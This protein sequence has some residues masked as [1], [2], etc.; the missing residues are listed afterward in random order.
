MS[1]VVF[2]NGNTMADALGGI[3]RSYR[4]GFEKLGYEF[5]DINLT[6]KDRATKQLDALLRTDVALAFSFMGIGS[7]V[8]VGRPGG[9]TSVIWET[10]G[11][12]Y[13][14]L[15]GDSPSYFFDRHVLPNPGYVALYG[16]P[17]HFELRK[18]FPHINGLIDTYS[19]TAIDVLGKDE[20]DF[21]KK[22][23]GTIVL[24]KNSNDP[25][26]LKT[27]WASLPPKIGS[28]ILEVASELEARI[29][30][31]ATTQIDDL[32]TAYFKD[33]DIDIAALT[34]LRLF[35]V[36]QLDDYLRRLKST[37]VVES[38]LDLPVVLN[39]Y[40]WDHV[41]FSGRR[42]KYIQ[43]GQFE[44]SRAMIRE[45][46][47]MLDISPN[48][49]LAPHDRV[50]RAFGSRTLCL[51][52]EQEFFASALPHSADFFYQ[53][54]GESLR[55]KVSDVLAH[56]QRYLEIGATVAEAFMQKFPAEAFAGQLLN[57]APLARFNQLPAAPEGTPNYF[58]WPP[59]KL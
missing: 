40:N 26:K 7:D 28:V 14:S 20:V 43:G 3:G 48:T 52:N 18:R 41:D 38:L 13:F 6:D 55:S 54:N 10:L 59:A 16:F 22:A 8:L 44:T 1:A 33:R 53:F 15:Y 29:D 31:K 2:L 35:V 51:T 49:G 58:A 11:V 24:L 42:L 9:T 25:K 23:E 27:L 46:L 57:L 32:V 4:S 34:K 30:D 5:I 39:G 36:A 19:P 17:E 47:A 56:R 21:R 37:M 45:N 12:P 50:L